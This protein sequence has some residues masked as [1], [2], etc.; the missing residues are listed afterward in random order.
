MANKTKEQHQAKY[1]FWQ[2]HINSCENSGLTQ[3]EYCRQNGLAIQ[4]FGYWKRKILNKSFV[5]DKPRFFP[6]TVK[7]NRSG[8]PAGILLSV[9]AGRFRIEVG[10][11]FNETILK[12]LI[13]ALEQL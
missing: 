3:K 4:T 12:K 7:Q 1:E 5:F 8:K 10:E 9:Q 2:N 13:V 6:L 11:N